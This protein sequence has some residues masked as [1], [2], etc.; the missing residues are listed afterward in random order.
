MEKLLV[1]DLRKLEKQVLQ[2]EISY[3]KMVELINEKIKK[4]SEKAVKEFKEKLVSELNEF[5]IDEM[6]V[7]GLEPNE[8][9]RI[10]LEKLK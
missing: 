6:E 1:L 7:N 8:L 10:I 9:M 5:D 2:G 3:S 4:E